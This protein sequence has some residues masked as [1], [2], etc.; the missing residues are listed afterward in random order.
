[1]D[2]ARPAVLVDDDTGTGVLVVAAATCTARVLAFVI[3]HTSGFLCAAAPA[4]VYD[5]LRVPSL[6]PPGRAPTGIDYG[7]SI[8]A[9]DGIS[10]GISAA[11]RARVL[12][13]LASPTTDPKDLTRP[14]HVISVHVHDTACATLPYMACRLV[15]SHRLPAVA[16]YAHVIG[17]RD[18]TSLAD[19]AELSAFAAEH[20]LL[21]AHT[22]ERASAQQE[23]LAR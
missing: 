22:G 17:R 12:R 8:D 5:R 18:T 23:K 1:M 7:V 9:A 4:P 20:D 6:A 3:R 11:D 21:L 19:T 15:R 2:D 10:T 16:G 13:L 14:G